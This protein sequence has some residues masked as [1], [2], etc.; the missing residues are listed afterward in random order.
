MDIEVGA[1][2]EVESKVERVRRYL[3]SRE[4]AGVLLSRQDDFAWLTGGKDNHVSQG[5]D[6]GVCSLLVTR[7]GRFALTNRIEADRLRDE[8]IGDQGWEWKVFDWFRPGQLAAA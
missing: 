5:S 8:E 7:D 6:A 4:L 3:A 2:A 1:R